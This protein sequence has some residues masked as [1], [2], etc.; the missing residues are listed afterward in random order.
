[1]QI[2]LAGA[3]LAELL[4]S[5]QAYPR[6]AHLPCLLSQLWLLL[7]GRPWSTQSLENEKLG[8]PVL[9]TED[10]QTVGYSIPHAYH[11]LVVISLIIY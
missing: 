7:P 4:P 8:P 6:P 2:L 3:Q 5:S 10:R 9:K 11:V 1:M